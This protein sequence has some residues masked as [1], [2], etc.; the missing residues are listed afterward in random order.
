MKFAEIIGQEAIKA[1]LRKT[2]HANR[3]SH[4]QLLL[5]P[6]GCGN[7]PLA[8]AYAQYLNCTQRTPDDSCGT[9]PSCIKYQKLAHPDLHFIYPISTTREVTKKPVSK[10]FIDKWRSLFLEK[11]GYFDYSSW[12]N[13]IGI[14]KKQA[15]INAEDCSE[16]LHSLSYTNYESY[17]K[18]MII[19][20][21]EKLYYS[22]APKILKILEEPPDRTLFLLV[23]SDFD[24]IISTI[25]S[26]VQVI[27]VPAITEA[28]ME[29]YLSTFHTNQAQNRTVVSLA[30]GNLVKA[31][32]LLDNS[33][34]DVDYL[35]RFSQWID[36]CMK[37]DYHALLGFSSGLGQF[38]REELIHFC[39]YG[40]KILRCCFLN[41]M[42]LKEL[43]KV[44]THEAGYIE[45]FAPLTRSNVG[46][47]M[48]NDLNQTINHIER[49]ANTGILFYDLSLQFTRYLTV[50]KRN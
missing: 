20:G 13:Q 26:R 11:K 46:F 25:Q 40:L 35:V 14:E 31:M 2:V 10:L 19:W 18:V 4:A 41:N 6:E 12:S 9:C 39:Q 17:Y 36:H 3:I 22:A 45:K 15:I 27:K 5:G 44:T 49:N 7:L 42:S 30:G 34:Q 16:I 1:R 28:D 21:V 24:Q 48:T 32:R 38:S 47:Q 23:T 37:R 29:N 8:V 33:D 43:Q 50:K